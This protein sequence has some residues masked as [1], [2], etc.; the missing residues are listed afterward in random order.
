MFKK[1]NPFTTIVTML[2]VL[3]VIIVILSGAVPSIIKMRD[4]INDRANYIM[5]IDD[6]KNLP[7]R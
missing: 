4:K 5:S 3:F 1:G 6:V 2:I 7:V